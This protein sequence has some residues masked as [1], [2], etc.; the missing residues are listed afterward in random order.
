MEASYKVLVQKNEELY[1]PAW[2]I[3]QEQ[4]FQPSL[5]VVIPARNE[6][7]VI[8]ETLNW[9]GALLSPMDRVHVIAD[10]CT[11]RTADIAWRH[12][13]IVHRRRTGA[14]GKGAALFWWLDQTHDQSS[15]NDPILI[16]D[17]DSRAAPDLIPLLRERIR[18]GQQVIQAR[19]APMVTSSSPVALLAALSEVVEHRVKG[20]LRSLLGWPVRLRGTGM[21][22]RRGVLE[23]L[24]PRLASFV[25]DTELTLLLAE[26]GIQIHYLDQSYI[27][28]PKPEN[29]AG[30]S[31]QRAR[32]FRGQLEV[33]CVHWR[34]V[35]RLLGRGPAGWSLLGSIFLR[36][37]VLFLAFKFLIAVVFTALFLIGNAVWA[38]AA[39]GIV[40]TDIAA[41]VCLYFTGLRYVPDR[42][43]MLGALLRLPAYVLMWINSVVLSASGGKSWF[44]V[45]TAG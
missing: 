29:E 6:A 25:E 35:L 11:D 30:A 27:A 4:D 8:G 44:R 9:L 31:A 14:A 17:A 7:A 5:Q 33:F 12:G 34:S 37:V 3:K 10:H 36:P 13:A 38:A 40:L 24:A 16:L 22:I 15:E 21:L 45:R 2:E 32:W 18:E 39:A 41:E 23:K 19:I 28:D 42:R 26:R 1:L 20:R 43:I